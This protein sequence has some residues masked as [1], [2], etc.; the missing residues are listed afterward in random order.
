MLRVIK[1]SDMSNSFISVEK[2]HFVGTNIPHIHEFFELEYVVDGYGTCLIDGQA[3]PLE[4]NSLFFLTHSNTHGIR[5]GNAELI[6][7]MFKA[8]YNGEVLSL[9]SISPLSSPFFKL[10]DE[11]GTFVSAILSELLK[12]HT[13]NLKYALLLLQCLLQ[14][15]SYYPQSKPVEDLPYIQRAILYVSENFRH[16]V[17][18]EGTASHLGLSA[19]YLSDIFVKQTGI[20]FKSYVNNLQF[21]HAKN[22]LVC[23]S[24]PISEI[25]RLSG[26]GDYANFS[27]RFKALYGMTPSEYRQNEK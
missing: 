13:T 25:Y 15:I 8:E 10:T 16:G 24:L 4:K 22:L 26:F 17:T 19:T 1:E 21:S 2:K 6:T 12:V 7:V 9:P 20:N 3:Y 5:D 23:T 27:R 14:K 11:D 18:L